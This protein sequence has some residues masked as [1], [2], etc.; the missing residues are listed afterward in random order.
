MNEPVAERT[1]RVE[2]PSLT[3]RELALEKM[4][5][6]IQ[7]F[8]FRPGDR[9]I[10]RDLAEQLGVSRTIVRE[11]LRHL[12]SEGLVTNIKHRGPVVSETSPDEAR[13]IYDI[14]AALEAMA[15]HACARSAPGEGVQQLR[16]ALA[17]IRQS[18]ETNDLARV[19]DGTANFYQ[20]L[21]MLARNEL[22][23]SIFS[24]INVRINRL[25]ARTIM[26]EGR[27]IEGV[28]E[29]QAI[30][31][32]IEAG[33]AEGAAVAARVHVQKAGAIALASLEQAADRRG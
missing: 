1:L 4:R 6:S 33:D 26:S 23:W 13:Q 16:Q 19:L 12:E 10:E 30:V 18:Y 2:R 3:L 31:D 11:V 15:A 29:M 28:R 5:E 7:N 8:H 14:R 25:R 32:R 22:A 17:A 24:S 9:L 20:T 27:Q 21:F